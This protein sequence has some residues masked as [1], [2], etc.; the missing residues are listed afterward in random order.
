MSTQTQNGNTSPVLSEPSFDD[1]TGII[2]VTY[3]DA[4]NNLAETHEIIVDD[5]VWFGFKKRW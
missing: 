1:A 2:S 3:T 5:M 4:D